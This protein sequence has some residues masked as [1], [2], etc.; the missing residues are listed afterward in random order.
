[1]NRLS[2]GNQLLDIEDAIANGRRTHTRCSDQNLICDAFVDGNRAF[3]IVNNLSTEPQKLELAGL[4]NA[5]NLQRV[6]AK[7]LYFHDGKNQLDGW[8]LED[9]PKPLV[10]G[11]EATL[12]LQC[13]YE[14]PI[15]TAVLAKE[16]KRYAIQQFQEIV[17]GKSLDYEIHNVSTGEGAGTLRLG[18]GRDHG[19]SVCPSIKFNGQSLEVPDRYRGPDQKDRPGFFGVIEIPVQGNLV[20]KTNRV[21]IQ[22]PDTG[23]KV[24]AVSLQ[25]ITRAASGRND[26]QR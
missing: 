9:H 24:S 7:H 10:I 14:K 3:L 19:L 20:R 26:G 17:G 16:E 6:F 18:F 8:Y 23:G 1:M 2:H 4:K 13:E 11:S 5:S 22:F 12:V 25:R 21:E 15:K